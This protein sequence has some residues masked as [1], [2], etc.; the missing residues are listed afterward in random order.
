MKNGE[1]ERK[2]N[3]GDERINNGG[4]EELRMEECK[5]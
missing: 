1:Y 2:A 5:E 4:Y 3:G